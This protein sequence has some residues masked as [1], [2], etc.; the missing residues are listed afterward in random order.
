[1]KVVFITNFYNHHQKPLADAMYA[2]LGD[3]YHFIETE[4][5]TEERRNMGWGRE[6]KPSYVLQNYTDQST[7]DNC[8]Q[9]INEADV[10]I[11]GSAPLELLKK[12]LRKKR[13]TFIYSE[14]LYKNKPLFYKYPVHF[15]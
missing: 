4:K 3:G 14:R 11:I 13:L 10:A 7:R 15:L 9:L 5:I 1:M 12:R 8:Q 6:E 2:A